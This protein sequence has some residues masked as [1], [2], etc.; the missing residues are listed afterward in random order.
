M[1]TQIMKGRCF[2]ALSGLITLAACQDGTLAPMEPAR[3]RVQLYTGENCGNVLPSGAL[4]ASS[5]PVLAG[6]T[7]TASFPA[8]GTG[9]PWDMVSRMNFPLQ[10]GAHHAPCLNSP[11]AT[12]VA[13]TLVVAE[14]EP[15]P[16]PDGVDPDFWASLSERERRA[17][18]EAAE[19]YLR[20]RPNVN[21]TPGIV[22]AERF[23]PG[24]LRAKSHAKLRATDYLGA[25][26]ATELMAGGV[27]GCLL[28]QEFTGEY[29]WHMSNAETLTLV[30]NAVTA[31]AEAQFR[32][33]PMRALQFGR[34]GV[35]G[36]AIAAADAYRSDC[37]Q[38]VFN[39]I[40]G[41]RIDV[42]DP[43][44]PRNRAPAPPDGGGYY[45]AP[46]ESGYPP[47]WIDQ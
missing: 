2:L 8:Y 29:S 27:Y 5:P 28:Y 38:M 22:I 39:A 14:L 7:V 3:E 6:V 43:Y 20:L 17:L 23:Q 30:T 10:S 46:P 11:V 19:L 25:T 4:A 44:A 36:A 31:F 35:V 41:G 16:L 21:K 1:R 9:M 42:N 47:G 33:L 32:D 12:F 40:P 26:P 13:E 37:A 18:L 15:T 24:M 45:P 34:N